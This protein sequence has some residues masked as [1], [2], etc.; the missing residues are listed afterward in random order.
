MT[1]YTDIR[2]EFQD[3]WLIPCYLH[4]PDPAARVQHFERKATPSGSFPFWWW[5]GNYAISC[6]PTIFD[7]SSLFDAN[8]SESSTMVVTARSVLPRHKIAMPTSSASWTVNRS[9][10]KPYCSRAWGMMFTV[11]RRHHRWSSPELKRHILGWTSS[12]PSDMRNPCQSAHS[13]NELLQYRAPLC[14]DYCAFIRE[15]EL[16]AFTWV[17][18]P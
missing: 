8:G 4:L 1:L 15:Q 17:C 6:S 10:T 18:R 3:S 5:E 11:S 12:W 14:Y 13:P 7:A 16:N 2:R 9:C